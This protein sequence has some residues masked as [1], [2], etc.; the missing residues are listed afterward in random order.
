MIDVAPATARGRDRAI[1]L[2]WQVPVVI[3]S[4]LNLIQWPIPP[5]AGLDPSW[6]LVLSDAWRQ[7]RQFG[8]E[9]LFTFG[10]WGF[11]FQQYVL[12]ENVSLKVGFELG[13]KLLL[14]LGVTGVAGRLGLLWRV[15]FIT[16][17]WW[18]G[19]V[20]ADPLLSFVV[21]ATLVMWLL[22]PQAR[23]WQI[24]AGVSV[25][26][27]LSLVKLTIFLLASFGVAMAAGVF[28]VTRRWRRAAATS[29]G[30]VAA[31]AGFWV[32]AGQAPG[33][34]ATFIV[35]GLEMSGGYA[36]AM[37]FD[38]P[39]A[40]FGIGVTVM[41]ALT[42]WL[43]LWAWWRRD[44]IESLAV[45]AVMTAALHLSWK[46]GFTRADDHVLLLFN[47]ALY[48][49]I[50][51]TA[52]T[53]SLAARA[54][55]GLVF[56]VAAAGFWRVNARIVTDG[57]GWAWS[58]VA[59]SFHKVSGTDWR[60][61]LAART[62]DAAKSW[63]FPRTRAVVG[64]ASI[65]LLDFDQGIILLNRLTYRPRPV[66]QSYVA[67]TP[68]LL[69]YNLAFIESERAPD[70]L[71]VGAIA[72]DGRALAQNDAH[73]LA[74][75]PR[76]YEPVLEERGYTLL[77]RRSVQPPPRSQVLTPLLDVEARPGQTI[78]LP[79]ETSHALWL[80][81]HVHRSALGHLRSLFYKPAM[82]MLIAENE[83]ARGRF[84]L[85]PGIAEAGFVLQPFLADQTDL[86]PFLR[87]E[88]MRRARR[89]RIEAIEGQERYW[90]SLD[91]R[92]SRMESMPLRFLSSP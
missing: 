84:L 27:F 34:L 12:P 26:G 70:Y 66:P 4:W 40:T 75:L 80:Q 36:Q 85:V 51:L 79:D 28:L 43:L 81:V 17:V 69:D 49:A 72:I 68:A 86:G 1:R 73:L 47:F 59:D 22:A 67:Y 37:V 50:A 60:P 16:V 88:G 89:I 23:T 9:V 8:P 31:L 7:Q 13:A 2:A 25:L 90:S 54:L 78:D 38:E 45:A 63:E 46:H 77:K 61:D 52:L 57:P 76:R 74:E 42:A 19:P 33:N 30:Y 44:S 21:V 56:V 53:R 24:A 83:S 64:D 5:E 82:L 39:W 71:L 11:L 92:V 32:L 3:I 48:L 87:G 6:Q 65:D 35:R 29:A 41:V 15:L 55:L 62:A 14:A 10:P 91:V 20:L 18:L 58:R